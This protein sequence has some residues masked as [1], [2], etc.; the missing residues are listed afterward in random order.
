LATRAALTADRR[1]RLELR[2]SAHVLF[3]LELFVDRRIA[4]Y[5][6]V[7]YLLVPAQL[8]FFPLL[9]TVTPVI[10]LARALLV[11]TWLCAGHVG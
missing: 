3:V 8:Y 7:L 1:R 11:L 10:E 2:C 9:N 6:V 4:L 5:S